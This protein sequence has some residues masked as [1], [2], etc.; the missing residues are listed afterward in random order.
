LTQT[1]LQRRLVRL[2]SAINRKA[3]RVGVKGRVSAESLFL[4]IL[5]SR[6]NEGIVRCPYCGVEVDPMQGSFDHRVP[7]DRG[8]SN[9]RENI[10]FGCLSCNRKKYTKSIS[11]H[12]EF[13]AFTVTCPIDG[14]VF[15]PRYADWKRGLGRYCSR[16]CSASSRWSE[17]NG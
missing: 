13:L 17:V 2:A 9:L 5:A 7:F 10:L 8:G 15:K 6:D 16:S 12:E 1:P 14:T 3:G 11:E 4:I